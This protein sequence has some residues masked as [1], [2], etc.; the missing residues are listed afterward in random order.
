MGFAQELKDFS[1]GFE[2]G[3]RM[4]REGRAAKDKHEKERQITDADIEGIED[5]PSAGGGGSIPQVSGGGTDPVKTGSTG[6][7]KREPLA[8]RDAPPEARALLETISGP[9]SG[10]HYNIIYGG[11]RFDDYADHPRKAVRI[12]TGPNANR[13]S[14]AAGKYQFLG[15]TWDGIAKKYGLKDFSPENQDKAA[16][17][18]A[19]ETYGGEDKLLGALRSGDPKKI[20]EVGRA[21]KGQWTSLPG[22]IEQGT[23]ADKFVSTFQ[24]W[25]KQGPTTTEATPSAQAGP[26]VATAAPAKKALPEEDDEEAPA[27]EEAPEKKSDEVSFALPEVDQPELSSWTDYAQLANQQ[28]EGGPMMPPSEEEYRAKPAMWAERGGVIPEPHYAPGG[29]VD[30]YNASRAY[31]QALP[32]Q[33]P[34]VG[35][36]RRVSMPVLTTPAATGATSSQ[37]AFKDLRAKQAAD[38]AAAA[39]AARQAALAQQQQSRPGLGAPTYEEWE[40]KQLGDMKSQV[41]KTKN[42]N[43]QPGAWFKGV[44]LQKKYNQAATPQGKAVLQKQYESQFGSGLDPNVLERNRVQW[45]S[46]TMPSA[47]KTRGFAKGGIVEVDPDYWQKAVKR[48]SP[49][50]SRA[51]DA[52]QG[53]RDTAARR[54]NQASGRG[55]STAIKVGKKAPPRRGTD[56]TKTGSTEGGDSI[57]TPTPRPDPE[58]TSSTTPEVNVPMP[59]ALEGVP[60]QLKAG[61]STF[62]GRPESPGDNMPP[63]QAIFDTKGGW[64]GQRLRPRAAI[65]E[66]PEQEGP[67]YYP[68]SG[69]VRP[70]PSVVEPAP[71]P[72]QE[73][74]RERFGPDTPPPPPIGAWI[75]GMWVPMNP[76][77]APGYGFAK[78]GA[79]PD[80]EEARFQAPSSW[81]A[82]DAGRTPST[83]MARPQ[84]PATEPA[85]APDVEEEEPEQVAATPKLRK[86]VS[87][88]LDGGIKFLTRHFGL[89]GEGAV[90]TPEDEPRQREGAQRFASGEGAATPEE[91]QGIDDK[92]DPD[93]QLNEGQR[94]MTRLAKTVQWYLQRGRKDDAEAAAASL[95]QYGARRFGQIGQLAEVAYRKYQET[96]DPQH[97]DNTLRS[98]EQAYKMIPDGADMNVEFNND[99]GKLQ[100]TRTDADGNQETY[101]ISAD[102]LPGFIQKTMDR[103][104]Y[105]KQMYRLAD[106]QGA[107]QKESEAI[108][109][110]KNARE[111]REEKAKTADERK[112]EEGQDELKRTRDAEEKIAT[113]ERANRENRERELFK[114]GLDAAK[115]PKPGENDI[116]VK[117]VAPL[118]EQAAAAKEALGEDADDPALKA[119]YN[120]AA[121]RLFDVVKDPAQMEKMGFAVPEFTYTGN[122]IADEAGAAQAGGRPTVGGPAKQAP[123]GTWWIKKPNGK[124]AEVEPPETAAAQ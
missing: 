39:E 17:Y 11:G 72:P 110:R 19:A 49:G 40:K 3:H 53:D 31:T 75:N 6:S 71:Q 111:L 117:V 23:T 25:M 123:D 64:R 22:G 108:E 96:G 57:P 54:I 60:P 36:P 89:G 98:L 77:A 122:K 44:A 63:D 47:Y 115:G 92:V 33:D 88:A 46:G 124:F 43:D 103:S 30:P 120:Q 109:E 28:L 62:P 51:S 7:G 35:K 80:E 21:L 20:A 73:P 50:S 58:Q 38:A 61:Q 119:A 69:I 95:M 9:E 41:W 85:T 86:D 106:S 2:S 97:L 84:A 70:D 48:E 55:Q 29:A 12:Q 27:E 67:P 56:K 118:L 37:Q 87:I 90:P 4:Y 18:L 76:A 102:E 116:D 82:Q 45:L 93:R 101:D 42:M 66:V 59:P 94:Q 105:W 10:G 26:T 91:I 81:R 34:S 15:S 1:K 113:E 68:P 121:S 104:S 107:Q 83:P 8:W 100:A 32:T 65:P 13:T 24:N 78:G 16:W 114:A 14:S 52:G 99:T 79:I 5:D 112:Y 74:M